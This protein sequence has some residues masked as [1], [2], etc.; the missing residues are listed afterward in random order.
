LFTRAIDV[1]NSCE[2]IAPRNEY[3]DV[4]EHI[5]CKDSKSY[6]PLKNFNCVFAGTTGYC[7]SQFLSCFRY[8]R[9]MYLCNVR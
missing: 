1:K 8:P 6:Q 2:D 5:R 4:S 3:K 7:K 9:R